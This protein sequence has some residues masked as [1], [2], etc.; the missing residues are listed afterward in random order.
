MLTAISAAPSTLSFLQRM[1]PRQQE[2]KRRKASFPASAVPRSV[3]N[4]V[5]KE[6]SLESRHDSLPEKRSPPRRMKI[7]DLLNHDDRP[8][9]RPRESDIYRA[10][11][12]MTSHSSSSTYYRL[13]SRELSPSDDTSSLMDGS[14]DCDLGVPGDAR[15]NRPAYMIEEDTF[16]W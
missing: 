15:E 10:D 2:Q 3:P 4:R 7:E 12:S 11:T 13:S 16:I 9:Y 5:M 1:E 8:D 6:A 14:E